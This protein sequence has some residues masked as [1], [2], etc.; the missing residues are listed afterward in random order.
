VF[1]LGIG[2]EKKNIKDFLY[3]KK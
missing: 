3:I 1:V 2:N